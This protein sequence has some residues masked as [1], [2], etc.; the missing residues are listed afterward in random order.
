MKDPVAIAIDLGT[1]SIKISSINHNGTFTI[2]DQ[3]N[4]PSLTYD[5]FKVT[6]DGKAYI[7]VALNLLNK[8]SHSIEQPCKLAIT[9][10]RS[11]FLLW[12]K[13]TGEIISP[14]ISWQD[15]SAT[16]F[17]HSYQNHN[18]RINKITGLIP[19]PYYLAYKLSQLITEEPYTDL[20]NVLVGT[21]D[22]YL[23]WILSK[24]ECHITDKSMAARTCLYDIHQSIW[25]SELLEC[26][27]IPENILPKVVPSKL[28]LS[29]GNGK[30]ELNALIADQPASFLGVCQDEN[31][32]NINVGTGA[33]VLKETQEKQRIPKGYQKAI[34]YDDGLI[35]L[36]VEGTLNG[37][38]R[39]LEQ[40][41]ISFD[42]SELCITD[43]L[44]CPD[45]SGIGSPYWNPEVNFMT[46]I[47]DFERLPPIEK[48]SIIIEGIVFRITEIVEQIGS[49]G[50][51]VVVSGGASNDQVLVKTLASCSPYP[52]KV[53]SI[54]E[55]TL[56]GALRLATGLKEKSHLI[57]IDQ[58]EN[59]YL[60]KKF[61]E[62]KK[63]MKESLN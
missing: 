57:S 16:T 62:W 35:H 15:R 28:N 47:K 43:G 44:C 20:S 13:E 26:F 36:G 55:T 60:L 61:K 22:S 45:A 40:A 5:D 8:V 29:L 18:K 3:I 38:P 30:W 27:N 56:R 31:H 34:F 17:Y 6:G 49:N 32:I 58:K 41:N 19:S 42:N 7:S 14:L 10:Q 51:T 52:L 54:Q 9:S 21:L 2:L 23:V 4:S 1:T 63:W 37:I 46:N 59:P 24:G 50:N 53:T 48:R 12:S 11:S 25:S 33:F 39:T